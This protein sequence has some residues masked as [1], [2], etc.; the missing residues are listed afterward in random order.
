MMLAKVHGMVPSL[1]CRLDGFQLLLLLLSHLLD[2]ICH[3]QLQHC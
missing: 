1:C 2:P 3:K